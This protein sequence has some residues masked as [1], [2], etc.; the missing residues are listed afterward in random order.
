[1]KGAIADPWLKI[2]RPPKKSKQINIGNN[3]N[4]FLIFKKSKN[5]FIKFINRAI[6]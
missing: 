1:M 4:F 5:S 2:I 6:F 3:Q